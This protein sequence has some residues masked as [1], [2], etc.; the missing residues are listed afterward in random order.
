MSRS[1]PVHP[2]RPPAASLLLQETQLVTRDFTATC[3]SRAT[4]T[5]IKSHTLTNTQTPKGSK[6]SCRRRSI[7]LIPPA[8]SGF[9]QHACRQPV[10]TP[11]WIMSPRMSGIRRFNVMR[12]SG[13]TPVCVSPSGDEVR[14]LR[15]GVL[16]D[17]RAS[18]LDHILPVVGHRNMLQML[19]W[20]NRRKTNPPPPRCP[21]HAQH[22]ASPQHTNATPGQE[23]FPEKIERG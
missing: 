3:S 17:C 9:E 1:D 23:E 15:L 6:T 19:P 2:P 22:G 10:A 20:P 14:N 7:H 13:H 8:T 18:W 21:D 5:H 12:R 11:R 16:Q 4:R